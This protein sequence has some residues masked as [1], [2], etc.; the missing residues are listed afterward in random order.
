MSSSSGKQVDADFYDFLKYN[1]KERWVSYYHQLEELF[2]FSPKSVLE[3]GVGSHVIGP[4]LKR[5][6]V[7]YRSLDIAA[8]LGPDI[9]GS[10]EDIPLKDESVDVTCAF[11]VLEHLPFEKFDTC[12]GEL[13][14]VSR[15]GVVISLPH[16]GPPLKLRFKIPYL[17]EYGWAWKLPHHPEHHFNGQHYW[18]IGK[19]GYSARRIR[20]V[21]T[22][23]GALVREY[24]PFENQYH[25]F[26][27]LEKKV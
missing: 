11:E 23:H 21:L 7:E 24:V 8:D 14:R 20:D 6:G 17:R 5:S 22:K 15:K 13:F 25:H 27:V 19:R 4:I 9:V 2:S 18:E 10:V 1:D 12:V 26:F 3:V 16:Y